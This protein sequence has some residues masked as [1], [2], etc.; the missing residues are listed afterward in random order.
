MSRRY[1][2]KYI[3]HSLTDKQREVLLDSAI[4]DSE[5]VGSLRTVCISSILIGLGRHVLALRNDYTYAFSKNR[6]NDFEWV[7]E[8]LSAYERVLGITGKK[9]T[10][11]RYEFNF[12]DGSQIVVVFAAGK[13]RV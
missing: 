2:T 1:G 12:K 11:Q 13:D 7:T 10:D 3:Y 5:D 4:A 6:K 9:L 8:R